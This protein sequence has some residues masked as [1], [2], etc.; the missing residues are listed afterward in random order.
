MNRIKKLRLGMKCL[1]YP[2]LKNWRPPL[3]IWVLPKFKRYGPLAADSCEGWYFVIGPL[4]LYKVITHQN[5]KETPK[6]KFV[7]QPLGKK[8]Y[9]RMVAYKCF[10]KNFYSVVKEF[11]V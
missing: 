10:A 6:I 9:N 11:V 1:I 2:H 4:C 7:W 3:Y 8:Y 5:P